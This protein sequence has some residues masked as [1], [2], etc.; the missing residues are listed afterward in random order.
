MGL[1]LLG[2]AE[3]VASWLISE[4][5]KVTITDIKTKKEL[6]KTVSRLKSKNIVWHLGGHVEEDFKTNDYIVRNPGIPDDSPFLKIGKKYRIPIYNEAALFFEQ[7]NREIIAVTG[8]RGKS[9]TS[10]IIAELL[11]KQYPHTFVAGNRG[12]V[13]M[14][15]LI[16]EAKK[17][18]NCPIVLE[19][20]SWQIEGLASIKK[21]PHIAVLTNLYPDH[22]NRY[23]SLS[24]YYRAKRLLFAF[25]K[26]SDLAVFN[27]DNKPSEAAARGV[28]AKKLWFTTKDVLPKNATGVFKRGDGLFYNY[29]GHI[30]RIVDLEDVYL[31]GSHNIEN[32]A[33]AVTVVRTY[34]VSVQDIQ[35]RLRTFKGVW[36]RQ[37]Q[38]SSI[39]GRKIIND[40]TAS[41]PEGLI[42]YIKTNP[43][44]II[45]AGG[46]NK[47]LSYKK[48]ASL[49]KKDSVKAMVFLEGSATE[50]LIKELKKV[51]ETPPL[52]RA[53]SLKEAL[54]KAFSI[55]SEGDTIALSPGATSFHEFNNEFERGK[56]FEELLKKLK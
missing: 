46:K 31:K 30:K 37:E 20:S 12:D 14:F 48:V 32:I 9:T 3:S 43:G 11:M 23:K 26:K 21:G 2:G 18:V 8:T 56:V 44:S 42:A 24:E 39:K 47:S 5:A 53:S 38:L 27:A 28:K 22:L 45:I 55:S 40:T 10:T 6:A 17:K 15:S 41:T 49:I 29:N 33:A 35:D 36:G 7:T 54:N 16:K 1:G 4:G 52:Y 34:G 51:K 19:L 13:P 50:L 25:Q